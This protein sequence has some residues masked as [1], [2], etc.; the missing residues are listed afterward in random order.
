MGLGR[1]RNRDPWF[2][3]QTRICFKTRYPLHY[4]ARGSSSCKSKIAIVKVV[5]VVVV[6]VVVV[7]LAVVVAVV[8][9]VYV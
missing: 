6:L 5:A 4:T 8:V 3:R 1:D 2:Y 7:V 9:V